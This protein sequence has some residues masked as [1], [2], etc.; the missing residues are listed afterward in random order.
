[1]AEQSAATLL[2]AGEAVELPRAEE[3]NLALLSH[4]GMDIATADPAL[5]A[6]LRAEHDKIIGLPDSNGQ[7]P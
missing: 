1:M 6:L 5:A 2:G 3:T 4:A 7:R